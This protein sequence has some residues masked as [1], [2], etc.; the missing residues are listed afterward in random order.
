[1]GTLVLDSFLHGAATLEKDRNDLN[2]PEVKSLN[3]AYGISSINAFHA[4]EQDT[5]SRL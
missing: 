5:L 3:K 2:D 1:M 4:T